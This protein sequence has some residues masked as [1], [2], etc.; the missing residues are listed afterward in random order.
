M[1]IRKYEEIFKYIKLDQRRQ[2]KDILWPGKIK[3]YAISS[4]TTN[5]NRKYIPMT[6]EFL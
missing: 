6:K 2:K 5:S 3:W 4:G 1:P